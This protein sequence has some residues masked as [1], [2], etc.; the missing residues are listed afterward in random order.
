MLLVTG[1]QM[2]AVITESVCEGGTEADMISMLQ[3]LLWDSRCA[4]RIKHGCRKLLSYP[5][6]LS[7]EMQYADVFD[8]SGSCP[9]RR[10]A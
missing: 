5:Y 8:R 2:D 7:S 4:Q 1:L 6:S 10:D 9:G 3:L